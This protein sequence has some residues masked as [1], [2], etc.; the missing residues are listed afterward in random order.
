M[1]T[2]GSPRTTAKPLKPSSTNASRASTAGNPSRRGVWSGTTN[3]AVVWPAGGGIA[4]VI[5][6]NFVEIRE[7][8]PRDTIAIH[9]AN[10]SVPARRLFDISGAADGRGTHATISPLARGFGAPAQSP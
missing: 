4:E 2:P 8:F 9:V 10:V 6:E 7:H 1:R 5:I 3:D